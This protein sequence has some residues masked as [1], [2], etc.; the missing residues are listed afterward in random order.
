[1]KLNDY[2]LGAYQKASDDDPASSPE[3]GGKNGKPAAPLI[4]KPVFEKVNSRV[5]EI[6]GQQEAERKNLEEAKIAAR[7]GI[8]YGKSVTPPTDA[9]V[10]QAAKSLTEGALI[11][12]PEKPKEAD[13]RESIYRRVAKFLVIIGVDE[14]AKI[15]PQLSEDQIE[16][17]VPE[18][19][20]IQ[21][22]PK[23]ESEQILQEFQALL[24]KAREE[25]GI[26]TARTILTKAYGEKKGEE[27]LERSVQYPNGRPF[28]FLSEASADRIS[29]LLNGES[30]QVQ[31][32]VLSQLEPK[33][34]AAILREMDD[35]TK[36]AIV[37]RLVKMKNVAPQVMES[38]SKSLHEKML[39]QN[40]EVSQ[41][42]D[43]RNV[44]AQIL[45]RMD[46]TT[47]SNLIA[48]LSSDDPELGA[49]IRRRLFTEDDLANADDRY[50]QNKLHDMDDKTIAILI[51]G[52]KPDF[53][54]KILSNLSKRRAESV[55]DEESLTEYL[56]KSESERVTSQF[57]ADLR[58]AWE[59]GELHV[60]GRDDNEIWVQ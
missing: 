28:D 23:E 2:M 44:I 56:L 34:A 6:L 59:A 33:K 13:G 52:K 43:G 15:L 47:E 7:T 24:D 53:R 20:A 31:A 46:P 5:G 35:K 16:K 55:L 25:G 22:V 21:S 41:S 30:E 9:D 12:V 17:I 37:L 60:K 32:L 38:V 39:S 18:I 10:K 27:I 3:K 14:A 45:K 48:A 51:K 54:E 42:L 1:M 40:T 26:D 49:D 58:R 19:A 29:V 50:L 8:W 4:H 57:F 11:K 36:S